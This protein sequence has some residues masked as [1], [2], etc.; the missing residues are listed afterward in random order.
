MTTTDKD[1]MTVTMSE[2][3]PLKIKKSEWPLIARADW[4][5]G[6][7]DFQ[8]NT[9]R[10]IVVREHA[11]GRRIVYGL[12]E[13]GNGGQHL[14]TRNPAGGF[15]IPAGDEDGTIRAIRRVGGIIDDDGLA[16][17][18]IA[19]LPAE[20]IESAETASAPVVGNE[21]LATLLALLVQAVPHVP[22]PLKSEIRAAVGGS[23]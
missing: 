21:T 10:R 17:E 7:Y 8:A 3:R 20:T 5:D 22:E 1:T 16:D 23:V 12:Q 15:M 19:D 9:K 11:D 4:H 14:G 13:A 6:Q 2:R 18:C